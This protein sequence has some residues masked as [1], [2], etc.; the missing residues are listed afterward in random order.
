MSVSGGVEEALRA[1]ADGADYVGVGAVF[2][3]STKPDK[4]AVGL[5]MLADVR[6][7]VGDMPIVAIGGIGAESAA[8][9]VEAGADGVAIVSAIFGT[10]AVRGKS[11]AIRATVDAALQRRAPSL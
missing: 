8:S 4:K 5:A 9:C 1:L 11:A 10:D 2:D 7:A 3:S 6:G